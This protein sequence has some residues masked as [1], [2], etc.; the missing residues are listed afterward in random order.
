[1]IL[2]LIVK[3]ILLDFQKAFDLFQLIADRY[4]A[5]LPRDRF[6]NILAIF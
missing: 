5:A 2:K 4:E 6:A 3:P 1:M